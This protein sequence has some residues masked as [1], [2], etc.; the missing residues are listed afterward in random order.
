[1]W[2]ATEG[3]RIWLVALTLLS[4]GIGVF[5]AWLF[6]VLG[7]VVDWLAKVEPAK[8]WETEGTRLLALA[9]LLAG[10]VL[11]IAL[12]S[13]VKQ[14]AIAGNFPMLLRWHYHRRTLGAGM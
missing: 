7:D 13:A 1:L 2:T 14:Q 9:A 11:L 12:Q 3:L 10:S 5:E 6:G 4:A 8:L